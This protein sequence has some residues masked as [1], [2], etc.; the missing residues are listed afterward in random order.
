MSSVFNVFTFMAMTIGCVGLFGLTAFSA[1]QRTKELGIRKVLGA[2]VSELIVKI[3]L[4]NLPGL[5]YSPFLLQ[6]R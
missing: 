4:R 6:A 3:L 2:S 5:L 1:E